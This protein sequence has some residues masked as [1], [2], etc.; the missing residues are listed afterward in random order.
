MDLFQ[1]WKAQIV[2]ELEAARH[3]MASEMEA[4]A[5]TERDLAAKRA[6]YDKLQDVLRKLPAHWAWAPAIQVRVRALKD[7]LDRADDRALHRGRIENA[8]RS[9]ADLE[10][11][12]S[13][14]EIVAPAEPAMVEQ[15]A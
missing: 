6:A 12:L 15:A 3:E 7:A 1:T 4:L 5:T 9:I 14:L 13:Q 10:G 8:R 11:A 2:A